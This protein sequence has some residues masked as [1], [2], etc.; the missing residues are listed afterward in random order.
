V[1][2]VFMLAGVSALGGPLHGGGAEATR[3][4]LREDDVRAAIG[5][6]L[7][8]GEV[9][10]GFGH[11]IYRLSDPRAELLLDRIE[12][13]PALTDALDEMR[14]RRLPFPNVELAIAAFAEAHDMVEG[15]S[16]L[17]FAVARV[18][19]WLAHAIEEY[20]LRLRYRPR[21]AYVGPTTVD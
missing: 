13:V 6:R 17:V 10:P 2:I 15:A 21:A 18:A 7:D 9:I 16:E 19:G 14:R 20:E 11:R 1:L 5:R 4:L 3:A 8:A 12:P